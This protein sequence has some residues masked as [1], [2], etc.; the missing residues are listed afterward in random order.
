LRILAI[1]SQLYQPQSFLLLDE[2][3]NGIHPEL[4]EFIVN[5]LVATSNDSFSHKSQVLVTTHNPI[6]MNYIEDK[7]AI[8]GTIYIYKTPSGATQAKRLFDLPRM[9]EK[10]TVMG[11]GEVYEDTLMT[12]LNN[13]ILGGS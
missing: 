7:V 4:I 5:E 2:I 3:E 13:E 11:A 8:A 9:R 1:L 6:V 12:Q 10:L